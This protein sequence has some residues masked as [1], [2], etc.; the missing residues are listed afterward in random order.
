MKRN[1]LKEILTERGK[2][3]QSRIYLLWSIIAYYL[4]LGILTAGGLNPKYDLDMDKFKI[5]IEALEY[6]MVLFAGYTFGGKFL[7]VVKVIGTSRGKKD[8]KE[9]QNDPN[10]GS[11]E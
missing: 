9:E 8:V 10:M 7:D 1:I 11:E 3:S 2:Y 4:T 5:I 6:A